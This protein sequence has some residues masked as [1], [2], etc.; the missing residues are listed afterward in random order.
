MAESFQ[1]LAASCISTSRSTEAM[2]R[3]TVTENAAMN[4]IIKAFCY[5][6]FQCGMFRN[7]QYPWLAGSPDGV[8]LINLNQTAF[9]T[10]GDTD[11]L[12]LVCS[13][14]IKA[15]IAASSLSTAVS[16]ASVDLL[17][18]EMGTWAFLDRVPRAHIGQILQ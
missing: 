8:A 9:N 2:M 10:T 7:R 11:P 6:H 16:K 12:L 15:S 1:L 18:V 3:G 4:A 17:W 14:E 5:G 13:V